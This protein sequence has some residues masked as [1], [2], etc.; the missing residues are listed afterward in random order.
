M[1][2]SSP[3]ASAWSTG[4]SIGRAG[5][6]T[7]WCAGSPSPRRRTAR[8]RPRRPNQGR[9]MHRATRPS[10]VRCPAS[11]SARSPRCWPRVAMRSGGGTTTHCAVSAEWLRSL[12]VRARA[13]SS[14]AV[15]PLTTDRATPPSPGRVCRP[16]RS[17][18]PRQVSGATSPWPRTRPRPALSGRPS[19]QRRL[20]DAPPRHLLRHAA[21]WDRGDLSP[22]PKARS[23]RRPDGFGRRPSS[24]GRCCRVPSSRRPKAKCTPVCGRAR[25]AVAERATA[26]G[27]AERGYARSC[28]RVES[29]WTDRRRRP[30]LRGADAARKARSA[31]ARTGR[32]SVRRTRPSEP[33][34]ETV[35]PLSARTL[36][37]GDVG[38][39][40]NVRPSNNSS[41]GARD[42]PPRCDVALRPGFDLHP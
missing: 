7:D 40:R 32:R 42:P 29:G 34:A 3:S 35:T 1:C 10:C 41:E 37:G 33:R 5:S 11:A 14:R 26:A 19:A 9:R 31:T 2:G 21:C 17:G 18:Q 28:E 23:S 12:G 30:W 24:R 13:C 4:N 36:T 25:S 27:M 8:T 15:W 38:T 20:R 16:T 22:G 6:S 39:G